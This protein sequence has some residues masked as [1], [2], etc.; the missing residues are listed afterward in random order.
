[1]EQKTF[2]FLRGIPNLITMDKLQKKYL[3]LMI[4]FDDNYEKLTVL[5]DYISAIILTKIFYKKGGV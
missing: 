4:T 5:F 2:T 3:Y 1:M